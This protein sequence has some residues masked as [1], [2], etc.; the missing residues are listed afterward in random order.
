M[1]LIL[2]SLDPLFD[3]VR[4]D[5]RFDEIVAAVSRLGDEKAVDQGA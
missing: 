4:S 5:P 1:D 3:G 2:L